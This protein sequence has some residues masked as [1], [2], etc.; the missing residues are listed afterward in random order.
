MNTNIMNTDMTGPRPPEAVS[1]MLCLTSP[2]DL[3]ASAPPNLCTGK[4]RGGAEKR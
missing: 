2:D 4:G 3:S 1:Q